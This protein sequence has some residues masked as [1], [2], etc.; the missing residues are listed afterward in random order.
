MSERKRLQDDNG[1]EFRPQTWDWECI[2]KQTYTPFL[3]I[4]LYLILFS[5]PSLYLRVNSKMITRPKITLQLINWLNL[6]KLAK[7]LNGASAKNYSIICNYHTSQAI[8]LKYESINHNLFCSYMFIITQHTEKY[9]RSQHKSTILLYPIFMC[10][11]FTLT[12]WK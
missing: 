6:E 10:S 2:Q 5:I 7:T 1:N 12:V 9:R 11:Y 4:S 3:W 8:W